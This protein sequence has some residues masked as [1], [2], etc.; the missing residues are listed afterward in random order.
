MI[1]ATAIRAREAVGFQ[2]RLASQE[3]IHNP[4]MI[5]IQSQSAILEHDIVYYGI[6]SVPK[7]PTSTSIQPCNRGL[8]TTLTR[9]TRCLANNPAYKQYGIRVVRVADRE[10][11]KLPSKRKW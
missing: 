3:S 2:N 1:A 5:A 4:S 6:N 9:P 8:A 11:Q 7:P 10:V